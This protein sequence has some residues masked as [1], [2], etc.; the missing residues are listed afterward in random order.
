MTKTIAVFIFTV[1][2]LFWRV[3]N[4]CFR[5][6]VTEVKESANKAPPSKCREC[7]QLIDADLAMFPG[8][9]DEAVRSTCI[10]NIGN[11]DTIFN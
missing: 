2:K 8:D 10:K 4:L 3:L 7:K 11:M 1:F 6:P 5:S 9:A